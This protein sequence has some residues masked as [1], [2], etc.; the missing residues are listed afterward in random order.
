MPTQPP[1][2]TPAMHVRPAAQVSPHAPQFCASAFR[3]TQV[4]SQHV[5]PLQS[6]SHP[7]LLPPLPLAVK[8]PLAVAPPVKLIPPD[9]AL[10]PLAFLP[11]CSPLPGS[12]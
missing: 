5:L 7:L 4:P 9:V 3:S 11:P 12:K 6:S 2:Q 10:P 1:A 8:P